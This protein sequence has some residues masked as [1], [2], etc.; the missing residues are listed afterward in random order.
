VWADPVT[1]ASPHVWDRAVGW[2]FVALVE[3][4]EV[5]PE[6]HP[7]YAKLKTYLTT[8]ADGLQKAQDVS[9]GWWLIMVSTDVRS[10]CETY[11]NIV[12]STLAG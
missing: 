1:G 6:T 9:G 11:T 8:L 3:V 5:F 2:Y 12:R 10:A 4:L 7:G